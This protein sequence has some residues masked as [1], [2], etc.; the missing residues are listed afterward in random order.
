MIYKIL[1]IYKYTHKIY[2]LVLYK[3]ALPRANLTLLRG[4]KTSTHIGLKREIKKK[5]DRTPLFLLRIPS[6]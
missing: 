5:G 6:A 3:R 2:R 4:F 1:I